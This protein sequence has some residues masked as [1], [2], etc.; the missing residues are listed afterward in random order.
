[1]KTKNTI[2]KNPKFKRACCRMLLSA[3]SALLLCMMVISLLV[4]S[5]IAQRVAEYSET[6]Y[7]ANAVWFA[8]VAFVSCKCLREHSNN[9]ATSKST[10]GRTS[11]KEKVD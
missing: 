7:I 2:I 5:G 11:K 9:A 4:N 3:L 10:T 1:M 6:V 8:V